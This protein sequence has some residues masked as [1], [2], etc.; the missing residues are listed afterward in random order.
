MRLASTNRTSSMTCC[1]DVT[2]TVLITSG[3][4][5]LAITT[6]LSTVGPSGA[7]PESISRPLTEVTR[8]LAFGKRRW[9]SVFRS[10]VS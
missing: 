6:A 1:G 9:I 4:N 8:S 10:E 5:C 7:V 3:P 2:L